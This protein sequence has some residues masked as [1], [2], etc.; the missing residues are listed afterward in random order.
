MTLTAEIAV[1]VA[2][3]SLFC[4]SHSILAS[5][6]IK[7]AFQYRFGKLIAFYR[8]GHNILSVLTLVIIYKMLPEIDITLYDLPNPYDLMIVFCQLLSIIGFIWSA[9][10]FNVGEFIGWSQIKRYKAGQYDVNDRDESSTLRIEGPYK[11][12]THP[13]YF[14]SIMFLIMRPVMTLTYFLIVVIFIVYFYIGSVFEE[15]RLVEKFGEA[16]I[17]YQKAVPRI[18][19]AK[20]FRA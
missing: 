13:V 17:E 2:L 3:V 18:I 9:K 8:I 6:K 10:Y 5:K 12:S 1:T 16:Y 20:I 11:Y 15:R 19:P 4:I 7:K 14:F